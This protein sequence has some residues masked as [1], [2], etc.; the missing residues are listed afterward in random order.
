MWVEQSYKQVKHVHGW[1]D[2]QVRSD[3]AIRRHW[4]LVCCAFSFCWWAYGRLLTDEVA[5]TAND[6]AAGSAGRGKKE[7]R[8]LRPEALRSVRAWLEP[9]VMLWRY[10]RALSG[11]PPPKELKALLEK[12]FSGRGL[13]HYVPIRRESPDDSQE[14]EEDE[15]PFAHGRE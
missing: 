4:Q 12:V 3:I 14:Q 7:P 11:M 2:Y 8:V 13:Y 9:W 5:E 1:S 10:W 15:Q 6:P